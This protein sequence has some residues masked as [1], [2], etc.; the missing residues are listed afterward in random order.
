MGGA[1]LLLEV[2]VPPPG[3]HQ[4]VVGCR[5]LE[6][7]ECLVRRCARW[8]GSHSLTALLLPQLL[9]AP[10]GHPRGP[11]HPWVSSSTSRL[12]LARE[13][14]LEWHHAAAG[15]Q[16]NGVSRHACRAV[17]DPFSYSVSR[18][19]PFHS[20]RPFKSVAASCSALSVGNP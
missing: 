17:A 6:A 14:L 16:C 1:R 18:L 7:G 4:G 8:Q 3:L 9:W 19:A 5:E 10:G 11:G 20:N 13:V 15:F 12:S 2:P